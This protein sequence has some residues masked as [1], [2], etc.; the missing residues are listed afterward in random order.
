[1]ITA[2]KAIYNLFGS[3]IFHK[4]H[5]V[6]KSESY[7]FHNRNI[8][9]FSGNDTIMAGYFIGMYRDLRMRKSLLA[10]VSSSEFKT[11]SLNSKISKVVSYIQY[12]K[13]WKRIYVLLK[14]F[15]PCLRVICLAGSK[16]LVIDK[17]LYYSRIAKI[18]VIKS[19]SDLDNKELFP[20]SISSSFKVWISLDSDTEEEENIDTD[21]P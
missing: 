19:S 18:S 8:G 15:F 20:V 6:F 5:S 12:N 3:G 4:P 21:D 9:L 1:M 13:A 16:K 2:H 7:E 11:M 10:T 17:V 14:I